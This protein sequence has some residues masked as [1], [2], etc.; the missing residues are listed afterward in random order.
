MQFAPKESAKSIRAYRRES[1]FYKELS[2]IDLD[3][4]RS[5]LEARFYGAGATCYCVV[6]IHA[7]EHGFPEAGATASCRGCGKA[8]GGGYHKPSAAMG[9]ALADAGFTLSEPIDGRG[10]SAMDSALRDIAALFGIARPY[11]HRAHA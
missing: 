7:W 1:S 10:D 6:W 2:L 9:E 5:V 3:K 8:G 11:I 4:G